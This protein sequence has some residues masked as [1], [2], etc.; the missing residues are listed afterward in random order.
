MQKQ[1]TRLEYR[2]TRLEYDFIQREAELEHEVETLEYRLD[3]CDET[4]E[5][6]KMERDIAIEEADEKMDK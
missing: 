3:D 5:T 6:L 2:L 1:V 4:I